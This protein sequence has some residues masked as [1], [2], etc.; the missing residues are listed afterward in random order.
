MQLNTKAVRIL[1]VEHGIFTQA[2]L[3]GKI[4][5]SANAVS[6]LLRGERKPQL[7]TIS[8]LCRVLGCTPNDILTVEVTPDTQPEALAGAF[9]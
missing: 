7:D 8:A 3:A 6:E 1:M 4:G 9:A 2:E 5:L